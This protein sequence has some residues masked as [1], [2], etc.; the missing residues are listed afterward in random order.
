MT[1]VTSSDLVSAN[2]NNMNGLEAVMECSTKSIFALNTFI[3][4]S[5]D[6]LKGGGYDAVRKKMTLY[7]KVIQALNQICTNYQSIAK[8]ANNKM[9]NYMEGYS[10]L[11]D[12]KLDEYINRLKQIEGYIRYLK[13][14]SASVDDNN[15]YSSKINYWNGVYKELNH[16]KELLSK[17]SS[18]DNGLYGAFDAVYADIENI[19]RASAGINDNTFTPEGMEAFKKGTAALYNYD[20]KLNIFKP[21]IDTSNMSENAKQLLEMLEQNWPDGMESQRYV[22]IQTALTLLNKGIVYSQ[23]W[24]HAI[25]KKTGLPSHMDCSSFVTYCLRAAGI[26]VK[27]SAYTGTYLTSSNFTSVNSNNL[28]PGDVAL[29]NTSTSG[30]SSNHIGMYLGRDNQG[31]QVWIHCSGGGVQIAYGPRGFKYGKRYNKYTD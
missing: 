30:G 21:N 28:I 15:D 6:Q 1:K 31:R 10:Y 24:R 14:K 16:Y 13:E 8:N 2:S 5:T 17:L 25:N 7:V 4:E 23:P 11:D 19:S 3:Y 20:P 26:D 27:S 29:Y 12:S 18:T 9:L 22:A